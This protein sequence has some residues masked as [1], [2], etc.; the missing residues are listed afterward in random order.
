ME[1]RPAVPPP[2]PGAGASPSLGRK[3]FI[4]TEASTS[5]R[6]IRGCDSTALNSLAA[7]SPSSSRS[8]FLENV[9]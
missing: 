2:L 4:D 7:T 8:R 1:T 6:F 3:L 9:K 5:L